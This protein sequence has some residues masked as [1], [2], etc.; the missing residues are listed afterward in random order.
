MWVV[1]IIQLIGFMIAEAANAKSDITVMVIDVGFGQNDLLSSYIAREKRGLASV[2]HVHGTH[3][4][5]IIIY[6]NKMNKRGIQDRVCD[7]VKLIP[8]VYSTNPLLSKMHIQACV[9]LATELKVDYINMS[10]GG[11]GFD[12]DEYMVF[13]K[14]VMQGGIVVAAAGNND[15]DLRKKP[16][17]PASFAFLPDRLKLPNVIP[18]MNSKHNVRMDKSNYHPRAAKAN[19]HDIYSTFP[20]EKMGYLSGTSMATPA[21]LHD[22]LTKECAKP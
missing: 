22:M 13:R 2:Q 4:A 15:E 11:A 5:G 17:Y 7:R 14:Y 19:G 18:V 8:C 6:G 10:G 9:T 3:V 16:Y 21:V 12:A 20:Y 1:V